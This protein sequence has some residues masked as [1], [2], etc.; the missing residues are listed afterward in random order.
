M[1]NAKKLCCFLLSLL[2]V[3]CALPFQAAAE[4]TIPDTDVRWEF[5]ET[6]GTLTVSGMGAIPDFMFDDITDITE[7]IPWA[8]CREDV[9]KVVVEEGIT[10]IG[11]ANFCMMPNL[12]EVVLPGTL[13]EIG[14]YAF[15][16]DCM[17]E[18]VNFPEGLTTIGEGAFYICSLTDIRLPSTLTDANDAFMGIYTVQTLEL[19]EGITDIGYAFTELL[20]DEVYIPSTYTGTAF[21]IGNVHKLV[22]RS[23]AVSFTE[24]LTSVGDG[25]AAVGQIMGAYYRLIMTTELNALMEGREPTE[26]EI[27]AV[28][29]ELRLWLNANLGLDLQDINETEALIEGLFNGM[30]RRPVPDVQIFCMDDSAEHT[31]LDL[32]GIPHYIIDNNNTACEHAGSGMAG[33]HITWTLDC[34]TGV[35]T[36]TGYGEMY[37]SGLYGYLFYADEIT[38]VSFVNEGGTITRIGTAAF[39][40]LANLTALTV[41]EGVQTMGSD[42]IRDTGITTL[43]LPSTLVTSGYNTYRLGSTPL[44]NVTVAAGNTTLFTFNGALYCREGSTSLL[45]ATASSLGLPLY[46]NATSILS[47]AFEGISGMTAF[48][49][50]ANVTRIES[51]AFYNLSALQSVTLEK[52]DRDLYLTP[53]AFDETPQFTAFVTAAD[54][55]RYAVNDGTLYTA[56]MKYLVAVPSGL[57]EL[58]VPAETLGVKDTSTTYGTVRLQRLTLLNPEFAFCDGTYPGYSWLTASGVTTIVGY[59]GSTAEWYALYHRFPLELIGGGTV[60]DVGF[61]YSEALTEVPAYTDFQFRDFNVKAV[62][63]HSDGTTYTA[64][65]TYIRYDLTTPEGNYSYSYTFTELGER[66]ISVSFGSLQ[67]TLTFTVTAGNIAGYTFDL[68][69][70]VL[71]FD[72]Y[73]Y[74]SNYQLNVAIYETYLDGSEPQLMYYNYPELYQYKETD[75]GMEWV[76][77]YELDTSEAGEIPVRLAFRGSTQDITVSIEENAV[78]TLD[79]SD[80]NTQIPQYEIV[81]LANSGIRMTVTIDGVTQDITDYISLWFKGENDLNEYNEFNAAAPGNYTMRVHLNYSR[82]DN[83]VNKYY[84]FTVATVPVTVVESD[85]LG[86]R[87]DVADV[88][89]SLRPYTTYSLAE[90]GVKVFRLLRDGTEELV[91]NPRIRCEAQYTWG[92]SSDYNQFYTNEIG[93]EVTVNLYYGTAQA[94]FH[95]TVENPYTFETDLTDAVLTYRQYL[96]RFNY[97]TFGARFYATENGVR[98]EITDDVTYSYT[99]NFSATG[100]ITLYVYYY[101]GISQYTVDTITLTVV[102]IELR[103]DFSHVPQSVE[104]YYSYYAYVTGEYLEDGEYLPLP[105]SIYLNYINDADGMYWSNVF[106][107]EPATFTV[108]PTWYY[109]GTYVTFPEESVT[110]TVTPTTYTYRIVLDDFVPEALQ[111]EYYGLSQ[112]GLTAVREKDGASM[113]ITIQFYEEHDNGSLYYNSLD[114]GTPGEHTIVAYALYNGF[115]VAEETLT[116]TV[117]PNDDLQVAL[118]VSGVPA[119]LPQYSY[120]YLSYDHV[121]MVVTRNGETTE[122]FTYAPMRITDPDGNLLQGSYTRLPTEVPGEYSVVFSASYGGATVVSDPVTI[123]VTPV[124]PAAL[125]PDALTTVML[126]ES[127]AGGDYEVFSFTA[128]AEGRYYTEFLAVDGVTTANCTPGCKVYYNGTYRDFT[129]FGSASYYLNAGETLVIVA[130]KQNADPDTFAVRVSHQHRLTYVDAVASSCTVPGTA[131]HYECAICGGKFIDSS[132]PVTDESVLA[133]PLAAHRT[134]HHAANGPTCTLDGNTEYWVC[135]ECGGWFADEACENQIEDHNSVVLPAHH[136]L[137]RVAPA[138]PTCASD[139]NIEYWVCS[140]CGEFFADADGEALIEDR[141]SVV[142][143]GGH[144]MVFHDGAQATCT[145]PGN[146]PYNECQRCGKFFIDGEGLE[147]IADHGEVVLPAHH[148]LT[149]VAPKAATCSE[150]GNIEYWKC[151]SCGNFYA[152]EAAVT[153]ITD[154]TSVNTGKAPHSWGAWTRVDGNTHKRIC[155]NNAAHTETAAHRWNSGEV[156]EPATCTREGTRTFTCLDCGATKNEMIACKDH[157]DNNGDGY[158]DYGCGTQLGGG[159]NQGGETQSNCVC[160]QYHTGPFAWLI[161]FFH[162]ITYFFKNLFGR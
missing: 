111:W 95:A 145:E 129:S 72:R 161:K 8:T 77:T 31:R 1:K 45:K 146:L 14:A 37:S 109:N 94:S 52:R 107:G 162:R 64:P 22:N 47:Y 150:G 76:R 136:T 124:E 65:D 27:A 23:A 56:D 135:G 44:A 70:A 99:G 2:L 116:V 141:N 106:T 104:Q 87:I 49:V 127:Y 118:D 6:T 149:R 9:T 61:D 112:S 100:E 34:D 25:S 28:A 11:F 102:P 125:T 128:P 137:N 114:T 51:E 30:N 113:P 148:T 36:L 4:E 68:T 110:V 83:G 88:P 142:I 93:S 32:L 138:D 73:Q 120:G 50:P 7:V 97:A 115:N 96:D 42:A 80:F 117:L 85:T 35:L 152:D 133:L 3:L 130:A 103:F 79:L 132:T 48:T 92:N 69:D 101:D 16:Y 151:E 105:G 82:Y 91:E 40:G 38:A 41:P 20:A 159:G 155:L 81:T 75:N 19:A 84:N 74:V 60:T 5:D 121:K 24:M 26:N 147:E 89:A 57:T 123:T 86:Y 13:T 131:E 126:D 98:R 10:K 17:L 90:L 144:V 160:G 71:T 39:R 54:E 55:T 66:Q 12:T 29:E 33:D 122:Y 157:V 67:E 15:I 53:S 108:Y 158:C 63:T 154:K 43:E 153:Q 134:T 46:E 143:P 58:T 140:A 18:T 139:G 21:E 62:V 59:P 78:F 156:T 119:T